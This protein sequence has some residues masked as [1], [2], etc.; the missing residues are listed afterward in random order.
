[1]GQRKNPNEVGQARRKRA[2]VQTPQEEARLKAAGVY[3][4]PGFRL[5]ERGQGVRQGGHPHFGAF[6]VSCEQADLRPMADGIWVYGNQVKEFRPLPA[7]AAPRLEVMDEMCA[8]LWQGEP[9]LHDGR[10]AKATLEICL[11]M[12]NSEQQGT[13]IALH[14]Q[15]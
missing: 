8:A 10:W 14:C 9:P 6:I 15:V 11:A 2:T 7:P 4:G 3:G 5:P 13:D 12:L 1:M